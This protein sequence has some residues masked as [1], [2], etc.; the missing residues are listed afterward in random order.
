[1]PITK[2]VI[3]RVK[4]AKK[5]TE[6]NQHYRS[7]MKSMIK[8]ILGYVQKKEADK[9]TKILPK[10]V[11]AIDICAK[12]NIIHENNAARKKARIQKALSNIGKGGAEKVEKKESAPKAEKK[13]A[14]PKAEKKE[15]KPKKT[16]K[17]EK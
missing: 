9:A 13:A 11:S 10:V 2:Q 1:M 4:Q 5:R 12:K 17:K 16:A 15:V 6:K 3:K 7:H 8:L 14:K